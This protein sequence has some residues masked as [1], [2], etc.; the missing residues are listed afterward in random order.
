MLLKK[1]NVS[2]TEDIILESIRKVRIPDIS[3]P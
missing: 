1:V 2:A 3:N